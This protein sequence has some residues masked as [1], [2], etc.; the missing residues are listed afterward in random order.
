MHNL[1]ELDA[2]NSKKRS[3]SLGT[4]VVSACLVD[5]SEFENASL[6]SLL[7]DYMHKRRHLHPSR[8]ITSVTW[9]LM[10]AK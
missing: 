5:A 4:E 6:P 3:R 2:E 10:E 9:C 8:A 7:P 1:P